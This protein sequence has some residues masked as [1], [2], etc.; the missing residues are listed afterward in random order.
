MPAP[1]LP[2]LGR[3]IDAST[4]TLVRAC[5][6][7]ATTPLGGSSVPVGAAEGNSC[8][9]VGIRHMAHVR[10]RGEERGSE[11]GRHSSRAVVAPSTPPNSR[12]P[13]DA[14]ADVQRGHPDPVVATTMD[15][16]GERSRL[17]LM[18]GK[19]PQHDEDPGVSEAPAGRQTNNGGLNPWICVRRRDEKRRGSAP[20]G[21]G[22]GLAPWPR[23]HRT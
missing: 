14:C 13:N 16:E 5:I 22:K 7:F 8:Q 20:H 6:A 15:F 2:T 23:L 3:C 10:E 19:K 12:T 17:E 4:T 21:R 11:H 9:R 1:L 18:A